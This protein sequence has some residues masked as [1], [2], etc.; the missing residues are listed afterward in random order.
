VVFIVIV[1][2]MVIGFVFC[3]LPS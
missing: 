3:Y 2:L 1:K